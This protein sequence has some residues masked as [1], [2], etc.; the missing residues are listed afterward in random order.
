[1]CSLLWDVLFPGPLSTQS[2]RTYVCICTCGYTSIYL[3]IYLSIIYLFIHPSTHPVYE[4]TDTSNLILNL[5]VYS[6]ILLSILVTAFPNNEEPDSIITYLFTFLFSPLWLPIS[7]LC[8][9]FPSSMASSSWA[10]PGCAD[11][12]HSHLVSETPCQATSKHRCLLRPAWRPACGVRPLLI[13]SPLHRIWDP[14]SH[15]WLL[16]LCCP[17]TSIFLWHTWWLQTWLIQEWKETGRDRI[18]NLKV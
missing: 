11:T 3:S 17:R 4:Y 5:R 15:S 14:T 8:C 7:L 10:K 12:L 9:Q 1:M 18:K 6:S 16:Q 2:Y 13:V